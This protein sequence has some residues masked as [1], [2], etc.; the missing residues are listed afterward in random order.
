[1]FH[2]FGGVDGGVLRDSLAVSGRTG[3]LRKRFVG[4]DLV[5]RV[6]AKTGWIRGA[7]ALSGLVELPNG[8]RR[9]F[10]ILMNYD[11]KRNG[12]NKDLKR[13]QETVVRAVAGIVT[14]R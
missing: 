4:T 9:W 2:S 3:T 10:S 1:M 7:S 13:I 8:K 14:N 6:R 12:V 5:G 11:R